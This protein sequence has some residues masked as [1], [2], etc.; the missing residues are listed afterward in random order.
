MAFGRYFITNTAVTID[1]AC[2]VAGSTSAGYG[3]TTFEGDAQVTN[4]GAQLDVGGSGSLYVDTSESLSLSSVNVIDGGI[5]V[6]QGGDLMADSLNLTGTLTGFG[7][8]TTTTC[9][10]SGGILGGMVNLDV[11]GLLSLSSGF[12]LNTSGTVNA[13]GGIAISGAG[14]SISG[15]DYGANF[16]GVTVNNFGTAVWT[17]G[18]VALDN[19]TIFNNEPGAAFDAEATSLAEFKWLV[20]SDATF[21][22]LPGA[23]FISAADTNGLVQMGVEFNNSGNV[24]ITAG[25][26]QLG[27][28]AITGNAESSGTFVA[29]LGTGLIF[30]GVTQNL[31]AASNISVTNVSFDGVQ[32]SDAGSYGVAGTTSLPY[33][34]TVNFSGTVVGILGDVDVEAGCTVSF[35]PEVATTVS[36]NA[37]DTRRDLHGNGESRCR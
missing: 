9:T 14:D 12:L 10:I 15:N 28:Y 30:T 3:T 7:T 13:M 20:G 37:L 21:N 16:V 33:G 25:T 6:G 18:D 8:V 11:T 34:A 26:L 36:V 4:L 23:T 22:N 5:L 24:D 17:G 29:P 31:T 19:G 2:E 1:G 32:V 35:D 27:Y